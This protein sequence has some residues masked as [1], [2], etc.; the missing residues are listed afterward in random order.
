MQMI[1]YAAF[2]GIP[3]HLANDWLFSSLLQLCFADHL[4]LHRACPKPKTK[5]S[6][7][8]VHNENAA[9]DWLASANAAGF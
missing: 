9:G 7:F 5:V 2:A 6:P 1:V 4:P 8:L 3:L